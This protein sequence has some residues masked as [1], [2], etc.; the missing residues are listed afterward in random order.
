MTRYTR[1]GQS[2]HQRVAKDSTSWD[3]LKATP[4]KKKNSSQHSRGNFKAQR[5]GGTGGGGNQIRNKNFHKPWNN[6]GSKNQEDEGSANFVQLGERV[7]P[8]EEG[9]KNAALNGVKPKRMYVVN[10]IT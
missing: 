3:E 6:F 10:L 4:V 2:T 9:K 7:K 5:G 8:G 1:A